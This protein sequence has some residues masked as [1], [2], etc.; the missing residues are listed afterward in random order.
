MRLP[1]I[2]CV[3]C[4]ICG[5]LFLAGCEMPLGAL[6]FAPSQEQKQ[7]ADAA[8]RLAAVAD[9]Q[10]LPPGS[11]ATARLADSAQA[12]AIYAGAPASPV[13]LAALTPPAVR[14]AW[15]AREKTAEALQLRANLQ[16]K[17]GEITARQ[18]GELL[19]ELQDKAKVK[20]VELLQRAHAIVDSAK[21]AGELA[22]AIPIPGQ[23]EFTAAEQARLEALD[24]TLASLTA[25]AAAQA[26]KRPTVSDAA[27]EALGQASSWYDTL[28]TAMPFLLSI[29]GVAGV[30]Y[31][32]KKGREIVAVR[33][34]ADAAGSDAEQVRA[35]AAAVEVQ[36]DSAQRALATVVRQ[37]DS[38]AAS[39]I[40]RAATQIAGTAVT[41]ADAMKM[42]LR[43][44]DPAT[45]EQVNAARLPAAAAPTAAPPA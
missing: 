28:T 3:I 34:A 40:G 16:A 36:R 12:A 35:N 33:K 18:L 43:G 7:S 13:D 1:V 39:P 6:R 14:Q 23:P 15:S 38:I 17:A 21:A 20:T 42:I 9:S 30:G 24:K 32:V 22:A 26:G 5:L 19:A 4:A 29:P 37:V 2:I 31:A 25:I 41:V 27:E 44:Q 11:A 8:A 45:A 10:G